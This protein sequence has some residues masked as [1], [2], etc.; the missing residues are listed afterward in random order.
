ML[1]PGRPVEVA[2]D[3]AD[4]LYAFNRFDRYTDP[5][6][7]PVLAVYA[8]NGKLVRTLE[9]Q[10]V[11]DAHGITIGPGG[12]ILLV[13][14]DRH[15]ILIL[16]NDGSAKFR[17]GERNRPGHPF[18]HPTMARVGPGGDIYVTDGYGNSHVHRF[19][20]TG[21][22]ICTWGTPGNGPGE[23]TTPHGFDFTADGE[24][25]VCDRENNRIQFFDIDGRFI[26][27]IGDVFHPMDVLV[28]SE[29]M[30]LVSDQIPRL[31]MFSPDGKLV[32]RCRPVLYGGHGMAVDSKG[33][34]YFAEVRL[35]RLTR[36]RRL[37]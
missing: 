27:E 37:S 22:L 5:A 19:S 25:V 1:G 26:R 36:L 31:S 20:P 6:G 28:D 17:L 13:D 23:F 14:R 35:N 2:V 16:A 11:G 9:L 24:V 32:G 7:L 8:P 33:N 34:L 15:E 21:E 3:G 18:S 10:D 29:G 12:D 4:Q 30:I